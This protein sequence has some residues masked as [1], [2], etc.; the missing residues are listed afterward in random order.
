MK[1]RISSLAASAGIF[2]LSTLLLGLTGCNS[3]DTGRRGRYQERAPARGPATVIVYEDDYDYYPGYEVYYSRNRR[4]YVYRDGNQWVRRPEPG[5]VSLNILLN[6]PSV[7]MD[8]RDPPEK[9]HGQVVR[10]YPR[11]WQ[12]PDHPRDDKDD[13]NDRKDGRR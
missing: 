4:E 3:D 9:H 1:L 11:N 10:S 6:T 7:R 13:K 12:R 8:F 2:A 5:G